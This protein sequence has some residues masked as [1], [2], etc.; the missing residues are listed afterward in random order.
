MTDLMYNRL[1]DAFKHSNIK[2]QKE[3]ANKVGWS[4]PVICRVFSKERDLNASELTK[5]C[6]ALNVSADYIL[7]L[8]PNDVSHFISTFNKEEISYLKQLVREDIIKDSSDSKK[9]DIIDKLTLLKEV[10]K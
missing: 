9:W 4:T 6:E 8:G 3:L 10:I 1:I 5:M 2:T 7:A